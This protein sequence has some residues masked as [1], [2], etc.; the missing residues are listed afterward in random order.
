MIAYKFV[1]KY[2]FDL[3]FKKICLT[4]SYFFPQ[5]FLNKFLT[6][7]E[8][9]IAYIVERKNVRKSSLCRHDAWHS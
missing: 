4:S 8:N 9:F 6:T 3:Q 5:P 2:Y 7:F 1:L